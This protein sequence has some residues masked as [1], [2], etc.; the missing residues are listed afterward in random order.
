VSALALKYITVPEETP[1]LH[2]PPPPPPPLNPTTVA[3]SAG[4]LL[5]LSFASGPSSGP[6]A[7]D[8]PGGH[9]AHAAQGSITF[10]RDEK[11]ELSSTPHHRRALQSWDDVYFQV[12][13]RPPPTLHCL[14]SSPLPWF[15]PRTT[16]TCNRSLCTPRPPCIL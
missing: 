12:R 15:P 13:D 4:D 14:H 7:F 10:D 8:G 1:F 5:T 9:L 11:W 16:F 6:H 3:P 2:P